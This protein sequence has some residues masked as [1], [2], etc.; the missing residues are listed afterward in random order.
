M[1]D[2]VLKAATQ[3]TR[4]LVGDK[5]ADVSLSQ[6]RQVF[7]ILSDLVDKTQNSVLSPLPDSSVRDE[8]CPDCK[9]P[10]VRLAAPC[11]SKC[12]CDIRER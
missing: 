7:K 9:Q 1:Q 10:K 6:R 8:I 11:Y 3:I 12:G 5:I 2:G 4:V